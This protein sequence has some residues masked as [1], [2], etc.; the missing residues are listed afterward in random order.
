MRL[1]TF[2]LSLLFSLVTF[3][4]VVF[5][6]V[7]YRHN[8]VNQFGLTENV[9][10]VNVT[11]IS[12]TVSDGREKTYRNL[13]DLFGLTKTTIVYVPY[14][15]NGI[16][17]L[18]INRDSS[19]L[20]EDISTIN[21]E[22]F[23]VAD[24]SFYSNNLDI[25][26]INEDR[27]TG[28]FQKTDKR[29]FDYIANY[30]YFGDTVEGEYYIETDCTD[31]LSQI[32]NV[33]S[34]NDYQIFNVQVNRSLLEVIA[35]NAATNLMIVSYIIIMLI[36]YMLVNHNLALDKRK[37]TIN[38]L[39]GGSDDDIAV[40]YLKLL[41]PIEIIAV[42]VSTFIAISILFNIIN[43]PEIPTI[44]LLGSGISLT[45]LFLITTSSV[46]LHI[47]SGGFLKWK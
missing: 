19:S 4:I 33:F 3:I 45:F 8:S 5:I 9:K 15:S 39:Y 34:S 38:K 12:P 24:N 23:L 28:K 42:L 43:G 1:K 47:R 25:Y 41:L 35:S 2:I 44:I 29:Y 30:Q 14:D 46:Y 16:E 18:L 10:K 26:G 21:G 6:F 36:F 20:F 11:S 40:M 31:C 27:V 7:S 22:F 13:N 32:D 37:I 17:V